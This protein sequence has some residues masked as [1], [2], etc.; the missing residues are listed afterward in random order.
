MKN[1]V[2]FTHKPI[3]FSTGRA[4]AG[5]GV[6]SVDASTA[7]VTGIRLALVDFTLAVPSRVPR[8]TC[9]YK[10]VKK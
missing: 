7:V 10:T 2:S 4:V 3:S 6:L 5:E 9:A 8:F 1:V